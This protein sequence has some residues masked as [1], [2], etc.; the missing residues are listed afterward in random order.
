[1]A[2]FLKYTHTSPSHL[3]KYKYF[4]QNCAL[5]LVFVLLLSTFKAN[6]PFKCQSQHLSLIWA[7]TRLA[8]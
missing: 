7:P 8:K 3:N 2:R 4:V 5:F 1:M 6:L